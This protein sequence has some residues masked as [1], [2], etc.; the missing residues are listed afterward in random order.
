MLSSCRLSIT[1]PK[2]SNRDSGIVEQETNILNK[3]IVIL[4]EAKYEN[5]FLFFVVTSLLSSSESGSIED[6]EDEN[7]CTNIDDASSEDEASATPSQSL[8]PS[9]MMTSHGDEDVPLSPLEHARRSGHL[10]DIQIRSSAGHVQLRKK[11][12]TLPTRGLFCS[13]YCRGL[14]WLPLH[15]RLL[16]Y[17]YN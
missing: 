4:K 7:I 12:V 17:A 6:E 16:M 8:T 9:I 15:P 3:P 1:E 5:K 13:N 10:D 11:N 2:D 14:L